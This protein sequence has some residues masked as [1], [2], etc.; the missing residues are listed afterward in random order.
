MKPSVLFKRS[1][2]QNLNALKMRLFP[3][4]KPVCRHDPESIMVFVTNRCNFKCNTCPFTNT[5]PWSPPDN[6]PDMPVDLFRSIINKYSGAKILGLVGGE[7]LLHPNLNEMITIAASKKIAVNISTNGSLLTERKTR[8]LLDLPLTSLNISVDAVNEDEFKRLRGGDSKTYQTVVTN[9]A[10]FGEIKKKKNKNMSFKLSFVTDSQNLF[11]I[12]EYFDLARSVSADTVFC[13][14]VLSYECSSV[15]AGES[16]LWDTPENRNFLQSLKTPDDITFIPPLLTAQTDKNNTTTSCVHPFKILAT[17]GAGN[18]SPCC[19]IP[20]HN[21][22]GNFYN[23]I[24][25]WRK[26]AALRKIRSE[27]LENK[28]ASESIC[29]NCWERFS[30]QPDKKQ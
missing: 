13:Q 28:P 2:K 18:V 20:P 30:M 1:L 14:S 26:G 10:R 22:F 27:M 21:R 12:P 23:D 8:Q 15:T 3:M 24:I 11:R 25:I 5:S 7:P 9:A 19:V 29:L 4:N 16:V 6:V 17:D